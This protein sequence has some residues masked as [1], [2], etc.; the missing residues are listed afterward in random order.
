MR[1]PSDGGPTERSEAAREFGI[2][3]EKY[4]PLLSLLKPPRAQAA[5]LQS[6]DQFAVEALLDRKWAPL[7]SHCN[8]AYA[9]HQSLLRAGIPCDFITESQLP[10]KLGQYRLLILPHVRLIAPESAAAIADFVRN[11]GAVWA[12]GRCGYLDKHHFLR[13]TVPGNGLDRVFG[14][15]E[16][17]EVAP[18][19][20][21]RLVMGDGFEVAACWEVQRFKASGSA[22]VIARCHGW[23]AAVRHRYG[24]G[25][26]E[27]W[28]TYLTAN[29]EA[30]LSRLI[31]P[32]AARCVGKTPL[33][34]RRGKELQMS[35]SRGDNVLFAVFTSLADEPQEAVVELPVPARK[36]LNDVAAALDGGVLAFTIRPG[37]TLPVL[38]RTESSGTLR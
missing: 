26:A 31:P 32:F 24:N 2:F 28:G 1:N 9:A 10:D 29:E 3:L 18:L 33:A 12:D 15:R 27:L 21:D 20:G 16:I 5:I 34:V 23:P 30:D 14:C 38:I 6:M 37:E 13:G 7:G 8:A 25:I 17:D 4:R 19:E 35:L 36:V 11:G 22:E